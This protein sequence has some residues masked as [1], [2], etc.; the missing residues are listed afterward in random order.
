MR[1]P[2]AIITASGATAAILLGVI[3]IPGSTSAY[4]VSSLITPGCH[5]RIAAQAL[6]AVRLDLATAAPL[7]RTSDEQALIDDLQFTPDKDMIDLGGA[8]L[9]IGTRDNDLKGRSSDDLTYLGAVH[10]DPNNQDE[11]CL[12]SAGQDEPGGS[13]AAVAACRAFIR[14]RVSEALDGLDANG[15]PDLAVRTSLPLYLALR[16]RVNA[17]LPT[18]YVRIGQAIHALDDAFSHTYRTPDGMKITVAMNWID[19]ANRDLVESRDGPA[20]ASEM[21]ACNDP[22]PL[23]TTKRQLATEATAALLRATLDPSMP[24][25][26]KMTAIDAI[27]DTY[28][29][30]SPGC[31]FDNNWC[32]APERQ[33]KNAATRG[34][35]CSSTGGIGLMGGVWALLA[36]AIVPR[37][38]K[39]AATVAGRAAGGGCALVARGRRARRHP[40][41]RARRRRRQAG[42]CRDRTR[43]RPRS[44]CR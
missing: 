7:P 35:G 31:T 37:R 39:A 1:K 4:T 17:L 14:G 16:G 3:A 23:R 44:R 21:D 42:P 12:R 20:H 5:E 2:R 29:S 38:R 11:H 40:G 26:Q 32:D 18:Y 13:A 9:L 19:E 33:Y 15:A 25:E 34:L 27:L 36:L 41:R 24:K 22:D 30:Y 8:T 6:R 28:V 10:G 43:R